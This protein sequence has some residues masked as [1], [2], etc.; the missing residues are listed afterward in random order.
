MVE[1]EVEMAVAE[2]AE[3]AEA[4]VEE[5]ATNSVEPRAAMRGARLFHLQHWRVSLLLASG[6]TPGTPASEENVFG[7]SGEPAK[8]SSLVCR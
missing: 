8:P 3:V 5:A 4:V 1:V 6:G 7:T 2:V